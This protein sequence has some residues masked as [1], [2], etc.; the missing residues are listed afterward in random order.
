MR[1]TEIEREGGGEGRGREKDCETPDF[2]EL[3]L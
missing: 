2:Y 1:E 3:K